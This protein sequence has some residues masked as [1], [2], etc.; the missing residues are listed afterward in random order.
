VDCLV[1][2]LPPQPKPATA[3]RNRFHLQAS[4]HRWLGK[5][6]NILLVVGVLACRNAGVAEQIPV[7]HVEGVSHGF[8]VLRSLDGKILASGDQIQVV[9]EHQVT[10][11]TIFH[12]KDGSV[13]DDTTVF[14]QDHDFRL[15]SDHHIQNG[16]SFPNPIDILIDA[17]KDEVTIHA[18]EK[19]KEKDSVRHMKLPPDLANGMILTYLRNIPESTQETK[20][21]F[22][23]SSS[24]PRMITL[25]I[26][27]QK[28][29]PFEVA[30]VEHKATQ[31]DIH[32]EIGGVEG[33]LA[34]L[35]GKQPPDMH[36]WMSAGPAPTFL[37]M[38]GIVF[39]GGPIWRIDLS[40]IALRDESTQSAQDRSGK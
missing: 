14:S 18:L 9:K 4:T 38:E 20:V 16:P 19:G 31:F 30:G 33:A 24:S 34:P 10:S 3:T 22:L 13:D 27:A 12:F 39:K 35:V 36:I 23:T 25:S 32:Y 37:R 7:H 6:V 15:I 1:E 5:A 8:V 29:E 26:K 17:T 2:D 21:P 28:E 11:E 40:P